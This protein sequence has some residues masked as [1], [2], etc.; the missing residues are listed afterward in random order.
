MDGMI[1]LP[2]KDL[3][4]YISTVL[5]SLLKEKRSFMRR[6][7]GNPFLIHM[8]NSGCDNGRKM[9]GQLA[10]YSPDLSP[11]DFCLFGFQKQSKKGMDLSTEDHLRDALPSIWP[12]VTFDTL[13]SV[14]KEWLRRSM[15]VIE[16]N[17]ESSFE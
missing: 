4:V 14:F 3:T 7:A 11:C 16:N 5:Q 2:R 1:Q 17:S 10:A 8:H 12:D 6:N 9:T 13:P 15:W